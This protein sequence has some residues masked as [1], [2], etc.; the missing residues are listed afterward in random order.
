MRLSP[1]LI[2]TA[3]RRDRYLPLLLPTLRN[4]ADAERELKWIRNELP[5]HLTLEQACRLRGRLVPLQYILGSQPF[6][7]LDI[8]CVSGV[9]IPRWETEEWT[10]KLASLLQANHTDT[11]LKVVD[12]CTGTGC[13]ALTLAEVL[14]QSQVYGVD[15]SRRALSTFQANIDRNASKLDSNKP[16]PIEWDLSLCPR[17]FPLSS[18]DL[19]TANPP[20]IARKEFFSSTERSVRLYEPHLAL[21]G[22]TEFY[23]WIFDY[24]MHL[25]AS[26]VVCEVGN[27]NQI[28]YTQELAHVVGWSSA[29]AD[30]SNGKP[31]VVAIWNDPKWDFL[32]QLATK[33]IS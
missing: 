12:F 6:G 33:L 19:I 16:L 5:A 13:I 10:L 21:V 9:L 26:A 32:K 4:I 11:N 15:I 22:D 7:D 1:R 3:R 23:K 24:A 14:K 2:A 27:V 17:E 31:R 28:K 30:D 20:Y 25:K 29:S 8:R 18:I